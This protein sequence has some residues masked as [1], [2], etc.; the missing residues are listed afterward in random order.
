MGKGKL[1]AK[2]ASKSKA[3]LSNTR[4]RLFNTRAELS[5]TRA[6]L[7]NTRA[8]PFNTRPCTSYSR[9]IKST[10]SNFYSKIV[11]STFYKTSTYK[12]RKY[13]I[14]GKLTKIITFIY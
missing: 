11:S 1:K 9:A 12:K 8:G 7:F 4:A 10:I 3:G 2:S 14:V 5:N 13:S 6:K